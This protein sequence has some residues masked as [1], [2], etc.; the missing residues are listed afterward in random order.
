MPHSSACRRQCKSAP[1]VAE[2]QPAA[3]R[4]WEM[5]GL[6]VTARNEE[7]NPDDNAG[8]LSAG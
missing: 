7:E 1:G 4:R 5:L 3:G 6:V 8:G 2:R